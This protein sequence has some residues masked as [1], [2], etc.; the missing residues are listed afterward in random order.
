[1]SAYGSR[2][3][4]SASASLSQLLQILQ[5]NHQASRNKNFCCLS[6]SQN[7]QIQTWVKASIA[8]LTSVGMKPFVPDLIWS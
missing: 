5:I 8:H 3:P 2:D 7:G 6:L 4:G 1:M